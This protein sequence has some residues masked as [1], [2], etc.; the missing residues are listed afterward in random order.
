M[1]NILFLSSQVFMNL[2][3]SIAAGESPVYSNII[4]S[5]IVRND[6]SFDRGSVEANN[7]PFMSESDSPSLNTDHNG[8]KIFN[9]IFSQYTTFIQNNFAEQIKTFGPFTY[10]RLGQQSLE[11]SQIGP[12]KC[13]NNV[14]KRVQWLYLLIQVLDSSDIQPQR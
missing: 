7:R 1:F 4:I 2:Y 11:R 14:C 10:R 6:E 13:H 8:G 12:N 9:V 5:R 3:Q